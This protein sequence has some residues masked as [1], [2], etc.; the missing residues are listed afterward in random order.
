MSQYDTKVVLKDR[1]TGKEESI[2][3]KI[4]KIDGD[5]VYIYD[6]IFK[7]ERIVNTRNVDIT[8]KRND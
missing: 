2:T 6:E 1:A 3:G 4:E 5:N 7:E 8:K